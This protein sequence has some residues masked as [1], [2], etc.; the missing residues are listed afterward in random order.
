MVNKPT[1]GVG[2]RSR[3]RHLCGVTLSAALAFGGACSREPIPMQPVAPCPEPV[4]DTT[5]WR[6][7]TVKRRSF[8]LLLPPDARE[9]S[10]QCFDS[11]CGEIK[12][13]SWTLLYDSGPLAG[14]GDTVTVTPE[15]GEIPQYCSIVV[16]GLR[17]HLL[18]YRIP[19]EAPRNYPQ[20]AWRENAGKLVARVALQRR[21]GSGLFLSTFASSP[22]D[23][24][25]FLMAV[26]TMEVH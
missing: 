2:S 3:H 21:P 10:V 12:V 1:S 6:R 20:R 13:G 25:Q 14:R 24:A 9:I 23:V 17:A 22:T 26:R 5:G 19:L 4:T 15:D 16:S 7:L 11:A 8:T 18:T